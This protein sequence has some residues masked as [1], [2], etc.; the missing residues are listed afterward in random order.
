M[1]YEH[2]PVG[3]A[4]VVREFYANMMGK[5]EKSC[6]VRGKWISFDREAIKKTFNLKELNDGSK[7]KQL[8][9]EPEYQKI[10]ELLTNGKGEWKAI[11]KNPFEF[12]AI[13]SLTKE[14]KVWFYFLASIM[15][16]SKHLSTIQQEETILLYAILK[17]YKINVGKI[18]E[19]SIMNY[20]SGKYKGLMPHPTTITR[21]CIL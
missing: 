21:L 3:F 19:K 4:V 6:Y 20:F 9:K 5:K 16:P 2:K 10:V 18:I 12:I 14:V 17:G 1:F 11:K 13:G 15:L 7:F 8:R